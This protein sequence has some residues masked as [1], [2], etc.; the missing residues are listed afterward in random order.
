MVLKTTV[1]YAI[2]SKIIFN[3]LIGSCHS[4][5]EA[6]VEKWWLVILDALSVI[7]FV[8]IYSNTV[9]SRLRFLKSIYKLIFIITGLAH[10]TRY[11]TF[12]V[13][14]KHETIFTNVSGQFYNAIY[15]KGP[16]SANETITRINF[17][18]LVMNF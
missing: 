7:K 4:S 10:R 17:T 6:R 5:T 14:S 8:L 3:I 12:Y 2:N 11:L 1:I 13:S 9:A 15:Y 18:S 16:P